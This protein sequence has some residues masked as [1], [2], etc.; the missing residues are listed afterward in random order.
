MIL[1]T[2][3][4]VIWI[5]NNQHSILLLFIHPLAHIADGRDCC[6]CSNLKNYHLFIILYF[7]QNLSELSFLLC[8]EVSGSCSVPKHQ[9]V[10]TRLYLFTILAHWDAVRLQVFHVNFQLVD[11]AAIPNLIRAWYATLEPLDCSV[12]FPHFLEAS[13]L[14]GTIHIRS[15][16]KISSASSKQF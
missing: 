9:N 14:K 11:F 15:Y 12:D 13:F 10:R 6:S 7:T 4:W 3:F 2:F 16:L 8:I 1:G 5:D